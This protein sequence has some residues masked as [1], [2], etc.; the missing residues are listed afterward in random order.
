MYKIISVCGL[1][2]GSW[3]SIEEVCFHRDLSCIF[4]TVGFNA[5]IQ[6][7]ASAS[8]IS[9]NTNKISP[10]Y[11]LD[12]QQ[13]CMWFS[14]ARGKKRDK[15]LRYLDEEEFGFSHQ[16]SAAITSKKWCQVLQFYWSIRTKEHTFISM[17]QQNADKRGTAAVI[18]LRHWKK[19]R[20]RL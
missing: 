18:F 2:W 1:T 12:M 20:K 7:S 17:T 15:L 6:I 3:E 10:G 8:L 11:W 5:C 4:S 13:S 16:R 9:V 14:S 19:K